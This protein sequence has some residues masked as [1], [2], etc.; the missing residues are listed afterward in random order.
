MVATNTAGK[1]AIRFERSMP[2]T[3]DRTFCA[4]TFYSGHFWNFDDIE[5]LAH[6]RSRSDE[7]YPD[8]LGDDNAQIYTDATHQMA[9]L[10]TS[11]ILC[12]TTWQ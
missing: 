12:Q 2:T 9:I 8:V 5:L 1:L 3:I 7:G 6:V 11:T 4:T 10:D